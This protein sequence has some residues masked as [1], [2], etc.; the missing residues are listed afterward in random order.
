VLIAMN[1]GGSRDNAGWRTKR[2]G[3]EGIDGV[4]NEDPLGLDVICLQ[5]KRW[6][7]KTVGR[8]EVQMFSDS[9][10]GK[11]T[12]GVYITTSTFSD[13]AIEY[14]AG[15]SGKKIVLI[16]GPFLARLMIEHNVGVTVSATYVTK[17]IHLDYFE[18]D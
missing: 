15:L 4:I 3:D 18:G 6:T 9:L 10:D 14:A 7:T 16:D 11:A 17:R 5:A 1:Y 13:E 12:K 8:P 2:T